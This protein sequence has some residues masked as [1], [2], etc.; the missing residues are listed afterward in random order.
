[1]KF[2]FFLKDMHG[3]LKVKWILTR[4]VQCLM[5]VKLHILEFKEIGK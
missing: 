1:M 4:F 5:Y 2:I 3:T